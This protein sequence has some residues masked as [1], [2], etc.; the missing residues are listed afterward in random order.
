MGFGDRLQSLK[1]CVKYAIANNLQIYVDWT[2]PI[3]SHN[4]ETFYTYFNLVN[5]PV[6]KSIDDIPEDATVYPAFWKGKLKTTLAADI[7]A[8]ISEINIGFLQDQQFSEDVIVHCSIGMRWAYE[9]NDFFGNVFRVIDPR[10]IHKVQERQ[11]K[12]AL[13]DKI[14]IHLRGTDR[15]TKI[16]KSHRM[17]GVNIRM[18]GLGLL[19]GT[20]FI[21]VSDDTE[22]VSIWKARYTSMPVLTEV[23]NLGGSE[24][25]HTKSKESLTVSK[26]TLNVN[27]LVDFLTLASCRSVL[28]TSKDSRFAQ[29]SRRL[30]KHVN[31][32]IS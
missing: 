7:I 19:N 1:M 32:I 18:V 29:E 16:D 10:I 23:D 12:Y 14:G 30:S 5:M 17:A 21:A 8:D 9:N 15:A 11:Q 6:L 4:G 25:T 3:W 26:D 24:G 2:D 13:K 22:F 28:S 27:L 31:T 20:K